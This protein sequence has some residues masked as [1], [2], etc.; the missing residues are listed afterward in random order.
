VKL[1]LDC[2]PR[3]L[4]RN[5]REECQKKQRLKINLLATWPSEDVWTY[6]AEHDVIYNSLHDQ[7]YPSIG[8]EP[9]T[10]PIT[11]GEDERAGRWRG[12][13]RSECGMYVFV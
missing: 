9:T 1:R 5:R 8:D 11:E 7:G 10:T 3:I 4:V 6:V 13:R 12:T 2:E